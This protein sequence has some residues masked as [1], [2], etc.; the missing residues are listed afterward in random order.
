MA[1]PTWNDRFEIETYRGQ[2]G[3]WYF[4]IKSRHNHEVVAVGE[5]YRR[6]I[7]MRGTLGRLFPG[8]AVPG[9]GEDLD[10]PGWVVEDYDPG[11]EA[12]PGDPAHDCTGED[13]DGAS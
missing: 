11:D 6:H 5:G 9:P 2:D 13:D 10:E 8:A 12:P 4:R 3:D 1:D 7:D